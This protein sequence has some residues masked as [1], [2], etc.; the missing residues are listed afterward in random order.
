MFI[1]AGE[2]VVDIVRIACLGRIEDRDLR[3]GVKR[4]RVMARSVTMMVVTS[5]FED[6]WV[7]VSWLVVAVPVIRKE[8]KST[9]NFP[10]SLYT[11]VLALEVS[12]GLF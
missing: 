3:I 11:T 2:M 6:V 9:S 8:V 5:A 1:E 4:A 10:E 7:V 12:C